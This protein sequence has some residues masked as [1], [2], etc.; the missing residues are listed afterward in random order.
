M[1]KTA[2]T[3]EQL[4]TKAWNMRIAAD[5]FETGQSLFLSD[6]ADHLATL[7]A[8]NDR[9]KEALKPFAATL[10]E[11][12]LEPLGMFDDDPHP[13]YQNGDMIN[14]D[15]WMRLTYGDLRRARSALS[16]KEES[17]A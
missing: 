6:V 4:R 1:T 15:C 12:M 10:S 17:K 2:E 14:A 8:E 11:D 5:G 16:P 9:L 13:L 7:Q 3:I